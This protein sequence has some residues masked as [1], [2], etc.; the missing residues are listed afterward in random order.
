MFCI[1][2]D[3]FV[4]GEMLLRGIKKGR[5]LCLPTN[6]DL[7][8]IVGRADYDLDF[9]FFCGWGLQIWPALGRAGLG[10]GLGQARAGL[11]CYQ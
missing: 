6:P 10:P 1:F 4:H 11:R 7:A 9:F 2:V 5:K 3:A 8:L